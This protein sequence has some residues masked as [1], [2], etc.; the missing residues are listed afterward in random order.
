[1]AS[2]VPSWLSDWPVLLL[3]LVLVSLSAP[4]AARGQVDSPPPEADLILENVHVVD[5][6]RGEILRERRIVVRDG[7]VRSVGAAGEASSRDT[8]RR[9]DGQGAYVIPG[10]WDMHAHLR[11]AGIPPWFIT[12]WFMPLLVAH[13]VTG[14]RDMNSAC[15][16]EEEG[17][18]C[19][20]QMREW[21]RR[22]DARELLG[23]R[24]LALSSL[25]LNPPWDYRVK[26]EQA[27]GAARQFAEQGLDFIKVYDRLSSEAFSWLMDEARR[28]DIQVA[29]HVPLRIHSGDAAAAGL[30]SIEHARAI[31]FDCYPGSDAFRDTTRTKSPDRATLRAMVDD[32]DPARCRELF[33]TMV[34]NDT[35]YVPTHLTRRM[36]A[37]ADDSS[38]RDDPRNRYI[39][40]PMLAQWRQD[41][42][43]MVELDPSPEGRQ[44]FRD[45]YRKGL[46]VTGAAHDAGV[47]VLLG[48]D[49]GDSYVY[50]GSSVH[51]ELGELVKAGL[52]PLEALRAATI[53]P[54]EFLGLSDRFGTVEEGKAA[55]LILLEASPLADIGNVRRIRA[56]V[57][58]GRVLDR[59]RLDEL[60]EGAEETAR[61]VE[62]MMGGG[63][64]E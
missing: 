61:K 37:F 15:D 23:P 27:R 48:T 58:Q 33:A 1:M 39:P 60:L 50:P 51:D 31:L 9:M 4:G 6:E 2:D 30:R 34:E 20:E 22:V 43:R 29:G 24:L 28:L 32:H 41:A 56:V 63:S 8:G 54:A 36:D 62:A 59:G 55:D 52:S 25:Q 35:W 11:G 14:V 26:E 44:A 10:L 38:F 21:Q 3:L 42:N 45:F 13:G 57:H 64:P 40:S 17:P 16:G 49:G 7:I 53:R 46:E 47:G 5:V 19:L 12:D 18:I